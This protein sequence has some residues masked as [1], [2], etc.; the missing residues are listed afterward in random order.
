MRRATGK[1]PKPEQQSPNL[2]R[3]KRTRKH[4]KR[5]YASKPLVNCVLAPVMP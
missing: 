1:A 2:N 4:R 3:Q 5:Y